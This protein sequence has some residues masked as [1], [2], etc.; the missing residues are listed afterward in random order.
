M[1]KTLFIFIAV[2]LVLALSSC[3]RSEV[4]DPSWD[5]PAGWYILVDGAVNPAVLLI[6]GGVH[7]SDVYVR[8]TDSSGKAL[9]NQVVFIEQLAIPEPNY[10]VSWGFFDNYESA[11][12]RVTDANGV[13]RVTFFW[14]TFYYSEEMWIHA[15][16]M[17]NGRAYRESDG[18]LGAIPQDYIS[19]A[20]YNAG[21]ASTKNS[22]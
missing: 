21:A 10:R 16:L 13:V 9:A 14:P 19:I 7:S 20:M 15:V 2:S 18:M 3:K 4:T 1:K 6:D 22:K 11:V 12:Q 8:V 17:I 5:A